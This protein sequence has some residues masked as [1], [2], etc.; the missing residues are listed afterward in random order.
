M[1]SKILKKN[2]PNVALQ[3]DSSSE[4]SVETIKIELFDFIRRFYSTNK[5]SWAEV[6]DEVKMKHSYMLIQFLSIKEAEITM[7]VQNMLTPRIIDTMH[8]MFS[9]N[10]DGK[11]PGWMYTKTAKSPTD[12]LNLKKVDKS[13]LSKIREKYQLDGKDLEFFV[14]YNPQPLEKIIKEEQLAIDMKKQ[15]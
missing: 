14:I 8:M 9:K 11:V 7:L 1:L 3:F 15:K 12:I 13:I 2:Q 10:N 4:D 6:S 5:A